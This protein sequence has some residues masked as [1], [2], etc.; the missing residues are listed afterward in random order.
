MKVR[1]FGG[2]FEEFGATRYQIEW[3]TIKP[4]ARGK[5]SVDPDTDTITHYQYRTDEDAALQRAHEVFDTTDDLCWG[6]VTVRK[7]VVDWFYEEDEIAGWEETGE[8][9]DIM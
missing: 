2:G 8:E 7:Q 1:M 4:S 9:F 6:V 5:D 3:I